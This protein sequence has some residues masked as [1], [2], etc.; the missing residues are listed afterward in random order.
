MP[1]HFAHHRL[2]VSAATAVAVLGLFGLSA[3]SG[4]EPSDSKPAST[5]SASSEPETE[6]TEE[7]PAAS[8]A[9][10]T[11]EQVNTLSA[12]S[13]VSVP[14]AGIAA[15]KASFTPATVVGDLPVVC[16]LS[17]EAGAA[18]G[19][20]AVLSGGAASLTAAAA[21]A[22]A[23]GGEV[24]EAGGTFT[25]SIDGQTVVGVPF[26]TLTK[27]TAGFENVEDLVVI[28]ATALAG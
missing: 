20:Y 25:T 1:L 12:A 9:K 21:N 2:R 24:T 5:S 13:G 10:C 17:F 16:M 6:A 22:T 26:T 23:A 18:S 3:C 4:G 19:S 8:G 11:E 27:E 7:A 15:A 14:A 28:A